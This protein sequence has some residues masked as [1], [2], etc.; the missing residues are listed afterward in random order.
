MTDNL[1]TVRA[2][3]LGRVIADAMSQTGWRSTDLATKL[4][5]SK[6]KVSRITIGARVP[7][8]LDV[9]AQHKTVRRPSR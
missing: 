3:L 9:A 4:G 7:N 6:S 8:V 1:P 5:W 2:A